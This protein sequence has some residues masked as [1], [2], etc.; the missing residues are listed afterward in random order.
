MK[1][2]KQIEING[3]DIGNKNF[4]ALLAPA[5]NSATILCKLLKTILCYLFSVIY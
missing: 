4:A 3:K 2:E 5:P 1:N